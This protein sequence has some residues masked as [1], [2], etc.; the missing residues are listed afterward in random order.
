[1]MVRFR[2]IRKRITTFRSR[3]SFQDMRICEIQT[4]NLRF[5]SEVFLY[6]GINLETCA[7]TTCIVC[8]HYLRSDESC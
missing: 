2:M 7:G 4:F 6:T 5:R 1:M 3:S 8:E